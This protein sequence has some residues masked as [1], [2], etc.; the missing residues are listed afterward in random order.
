MRCL[1]FIDGKYS[2]SPG[3]SSTDKAVHA[4]DSLISQVDQN[5]AGYIGNKLSCRK[6]NIHK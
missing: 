1:P 3:L 6:E 2:M 4:T 5:Y